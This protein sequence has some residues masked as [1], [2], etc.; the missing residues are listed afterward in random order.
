MV[1][2]KITA[3]HGHS[4]ILFLHFILYT[5]NTRRLA[6]LKYHLAEDRELRILLV[7]RKNEGPQ[8]GYCV[9][10]P[11]VLATGLIHLKRPLWHIIFA[12]DACVTGHVQRRRERVMWCRVIGRCL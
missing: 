3:A 7:L 5:R 9:S 12:L 10:L 6:V 8:L 4:I 2:I 11:L 1:S